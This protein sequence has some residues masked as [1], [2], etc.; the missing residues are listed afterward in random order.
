MSLSIDIKYAVRLLLKKPMFTLLTISMVAV[1]LGL[2]LYSYSLL[3]ALVFKPLTFGNDN[4]IVTIEAQF[5]HNHLTR[6]GASPFDLVNVRDELQMFDGFGMYTEGFTIVSKPETMAAENHSLQQAFKANSTYTSWNIF[7]FTGVQPIL[8][9]GFRA[10][11][12]HE[13][14]E[15]VA[16]LSYQAWQDNFSG[17]ETVVNT[18]LMLDANPTRIIGIMPQ[19]FS[20]PSHTQLWELIP[21]D[22]VAPT[23]RSNNHFFFA[24][25]RLKDG[26]SFT[27]LE[28]MLSNMDREITPQLMED[29]QWLV[30]DTGR[31]LQTSLYKKIYI[32]EYYS[33]FIALMVVV[34]LILAL[35]C[36]NIG[37]L[38]LA[39][40]NER[41]RDV[42]IRIALGIPR[43]RLIFQMLWESI[44]ICSIGGFIA[45]LLAGWGMELTNNV[46]AETYASNG[47]R[48]FWW[49]VSLDA[50]GVFLLFASIILMIVVTG[51]IPAWRALTGDVNAMLRDGTRGAQ[52][53]KMAYANKVLVISEIM[54]SCVVL[55]MA[56]LLLSTSYLAGNA[57]YG[58]NTSGRI[59]GLIQLP[60]QKYEIRWNTDDEYDDSLKRAQ[61]YYDIIEKLEVEPNIEGVSMMTQ[62]PGR[63]GGTS[64]FEIEGSA[65]AVYNENP[66]S[67]NEFVSLGAWEPVGMSIIQG[68]DFDYRDREDEA[69]SI[70]INESIARQFFPKGDAIGQRIR[71]VLVGRTSD[72]DTIIGVVSDTFH[73]T[74]MRSSSASYN[75]YHLMDPHSSTRMNVAIHYTGSASKVENA[76]LSIVDQVDSDIG[77][78]HIQS[79]QDLIKQPMLLVLAISQ[80]F[81]FCGVIAAFM[82]ASGIYAIAAN[83]I[84]QRTQ[85]IGMR[86]ALGA[87]DG[88][89]LGLFIRQA[90]IQL[91]VGLSLGIIVSIWL[92]DNMSDTMV[93][94][95]SSYIIGIVGVPMAIIVMVM[96]ATYLP[97]RKVI[98]MVPAEA[99]HHD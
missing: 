84:T 25:A 82:A 41:F 16:V 32:K 54:L 56:S 1:G 15:A 45:I 73:G 89:I 53:K 26:V 68:R 50:D 85:E 35:A 92:A 80:I 99:L 37:N 60:W 19:A 83:S 12:H 44:L 75:S 58:I 7:E 43:H 98:R 34:F 91:T 21:A 20:F 8:G 78:Y 29:F 79:Y 9:R 52:G 59:V 13:G 77:V 65:A 51:F 36:I 31:Y 18:V 5:D 40:V 95:P 76:F 6:R 48:P 14:A 62:L 93:I 96:L 4:P 87:P 71:R 94:A 70:I 23:E 33:I 28:Q 49:K 11:D 64:F 97:T 90:V 17:D 88:N 10:D 72:W 55:V 66:Y 39:R 46:L 27:Q 24:Y 2:T 38:L 47:M 57:D 61:V 22:Q 3:M 67:N 74:T 30:D 63:G 81:L 86:R 42:A 69:N